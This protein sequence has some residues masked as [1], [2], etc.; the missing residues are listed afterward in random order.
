MNNLYV[1]PAFPLENS[2]GS[3]DNNTNKKMDYIIEPLDEKKTVDDI[4]QLYF[5][6]N[7]NKINKEK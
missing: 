7:E 3:F 1:N 6:S 2:L 4:L 5:Y